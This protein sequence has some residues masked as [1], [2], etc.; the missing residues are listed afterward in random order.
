MILYQ[1]F[2]AAGFSNTFSAVALSSGVRR[3][4]SNSQLL[5]DAHGRLIC[6]D[7]CR[8]A[9]AAIALKFVICTASLLMATFA[10][11][12][13]TGE[14]SPWPSARTERNW[15]LPVTKGAPDHPPTIVRSTVD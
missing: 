11:I 15:A 13:S 4:N 6:R 7:P 3:L 2:P 14:F 9:P 10:A 5:A 8:V 1:D 12:T